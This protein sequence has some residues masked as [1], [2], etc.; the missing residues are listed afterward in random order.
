MRT[1]VAAALLR[2]AL[3]V[4]TFALTSVAHAGMV[5]GCGDSHLFS[6]APVNVVVLPY[7][8]ASDPSKQLSQPARQLT[9]LIQ[10]DSLLEMVKYERIAIVNLMQDRTRPCDPDVIWNEVRSDLAS[11]AG[12]GAVM[13]WGRLYEEDAQLFM[14]TYVRF[15]RSQGAESIERTIDGPAGSATFRGALPSSTI[16]FPPRRVAA[17][18]LDAIRGE[19]A[20]A[21][22]VHS[23]PDDR[24]P[25]IRVAELTPPEQQ[26]VP[27]GYTVDEVRGDWMRVSPIGPGKPGW[28]HARVDGAWPL[29]DRLPELYFIDALVGYLE[30]RIATGSG[31]YALPAPPVRF[32]QQA[33]RSLANYARRVGD[34]GASATAGPVAAL[35]NALD[36]MLSYLA[37]DGR[38]APAF[39]RAATAQPYS[40]AWRNL[41]N[42]DRIDRWWKSPDRSSAA[43]VRPM[44]DALLD[45]IATEPENPQG[46]ANL[47]SFHRLVASSPEAVAAIGADEFARQRSVLAQLQ[48]T[49]TAPAPV[50]R[51]Q[52]PSPYPPSPSPIQSP[53]QTTVPAPSGPGG[54]PTPRR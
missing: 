51:P 44:M 21:S 42:V 52:A 24:S 50:D 32:A 53:V 43:R 7:T 3:A 37:G 45:A 11:R 22:R 40:G 48:P 20:K 25:V 16:V 54:Y 26:F 34:D 27:F 13:V 23:A 15:S 47:A 49:A 36:G 17:A 19:F 35:A 29:R 6:G 41:Q 5:Q 4:A 14:Q 8:Y 39:R 10:Q 38:A 1:F 9:V 30:F 18:D 33:Q 31:R 2:T 46:I 12:A 28:V